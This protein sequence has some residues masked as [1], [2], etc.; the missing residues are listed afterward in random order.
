MTD[1]MCSDL[2]L[3]SLLAASFQ[4]S[5][6]YPEYNLVSHSNLTH[7]IVKTIMKSFRQLIQDIVGY[8][9]QGMIC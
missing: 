5:L 4:S 2:L 9:F 8:M 1:H 6:N 3:V 7:K